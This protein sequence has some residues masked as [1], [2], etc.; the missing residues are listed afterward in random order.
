MHST[1]FGRHARSRAVFALVAL[2]AWIAIEPSPRAAVRPPK[3][4]YK[5]TTLENGL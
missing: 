3:L 4:A 5:M 1:I 2:A